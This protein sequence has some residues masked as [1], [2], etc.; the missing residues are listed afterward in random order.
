MTDTTYLVAR[1]HTLSTALLPMEGEA[2]KAW[3]VPNEAA[4]TIERLTRHLQSA[5]LD[6]IAAHGQAADNYTRAVEAEARIAELTD[7][8]RALARALHAKHFAAD[9]PNWKPLENAEGLLSQIDNMTT[10]LTSKSTAEARIAELTRERDEA[11]AN[12]AAT[13]ENCTA[14]HEGAI[15]HMTRADLAE[16][17][18]AKLEAALDSFVRD[19]Q[20]E[21]QAGTGE[22]QRGYDDCIADHADRARAALKETPHD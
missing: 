13:A 5:A 22:Y 8:L 20:S 18:I 4:E 9:A 3:N 2:G 19:Q 16:A 10:G 17:R 15:A 21:A 14:W 1:L 11:R 6:A 7:Q 12:C